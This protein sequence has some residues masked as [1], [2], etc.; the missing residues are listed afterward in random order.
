MTATVEAIYES[1]KLILSQSLALPENTRLR[2]TVETAEIIELLT[3]LI[4]ELNQNFCSPT[5][6]YKNQAYL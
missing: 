2:V 1:G 5:A 4:P 3:R 6:F